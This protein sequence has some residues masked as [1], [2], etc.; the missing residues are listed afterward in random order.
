MTESYLSHFMFLTFSHP[1]VN[2][3]LWAGGLAEHLRQGIWKVETTVEKTLALRTPVLLLLV[4][5]PLEIAVEPQCY[6]ILLKI[7][8]L[9][10]RAVQ[11]WNTIVNICQ[12]HKN[13][14]SQVFIQTLV[15]PKSNTALRRSFHSSWYR[16]LNLWQWPHQGAKQ[17]TKTSFPCSS[18]G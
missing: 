10:R 6:I 18:Q 13:I 11:N 8:S 15:S 17:F 5:Q 16:G 2:V 9:I 12:H 14:V 1:I 3:L 7:K 4:L